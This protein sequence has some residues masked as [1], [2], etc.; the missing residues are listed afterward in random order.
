MEKGG[1]GEL[2]LFSPVIFLSPLAIGKG[3]PNVENLEN[4][5][6]KPLGAQAAAAIEA[7]QNRITNLGPHN[8]KPLAITDD[9]PKFTIPVV[10]LDTP[11]NY[12]IGD[13]VRRPG[14]SRA[15][16][17]NTLKIDFHMI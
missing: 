13:K 15:Q 4:W 1:C 14:I 11:P 2:G 12:K 8:I 7:C 9:A 6:G 17:I 5:H 10:K 3:F 16:H